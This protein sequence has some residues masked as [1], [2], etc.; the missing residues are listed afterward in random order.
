MAKNGLILVL[1][2]LGLA[3][4]FFLVFYLLTDRKGN[5]LANLFLA[6]LLL[7]LSI[8]IGK[9]VLNEYLQ[10]LPWQR[11]LGISGILLVGPSLWFYGR[12]LFRKEKIFAAQNYL[13]FMPFVL[14]AIFCAII[15]NDG[16]YLG[17]I[18]YLLVFTHLALYLGVSSYLLFK[19]KLFITERIW[20]WYRN[21]VIG[22][23]LIW[24]F[25]MGHLA[26]L[27]PFYIG[28]AIFFSLLV[29]S[30]SFL[31]LRKSVFRLEKYKGS[32]L[33]VN[34]SRNHFLELSSL[35][36]KEEIYLNDGISLKSVAQKLQIT[37]RELSQVINENQK[38][39]FS[40]FVNGYRIEKAKK[41]LANPDCAQE[42]I[43]TIAYDCG[44]GNVT[45]FNLA[46]KANTQL[47]PS[48]YRNRS[49]VT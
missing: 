16:S 34:D 42:K 20:K 2:C 32:S 36:E 17:Y 1:S 25:Y 10:L 5:R 43:A 39:N 48:Q 47:T 18:I 13:H 29:Y 28:G 15:P 14:F 6:T 22:V 26:G 3:Q 30:L 7:G 8:R 31:L 35:F 12:V 46:F 24:L 9:S 45:S 37:S 41:L 38:K 4:S 23:G 33:N 19:N 44:F 27:F 21:L 11:N 49:V 40:E